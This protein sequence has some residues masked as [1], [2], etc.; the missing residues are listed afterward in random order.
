MLPIPWQDSFLG[1]VLS[2]ISAHDCPVIFTTHG[3]FTLMEIR[4]QLFGT[5]S[6]PLIIRSCILGH[7]ILASI[8]LTL[9]ILSPFKKAISDSIGPLGLFLYARQMTSPHLS[10]CHSHTDQ[11]IQWSSIRLASAH[12]YPSEF[13]I[14]LTTYFLL[15][16][17]LLSCDRSVPP[18]N[19]R[20]C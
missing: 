13:V 9:G 2:D 7:L 6:K 14:Q 10:S 8:F 4:G 18:N 20:S 1:H 16:Y 19:F 12:S 3:A 15:S 5:H 17:I 11:A